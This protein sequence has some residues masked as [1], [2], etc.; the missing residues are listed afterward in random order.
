MPQ[1]QAQHI[2]DDCV[3]IISF[4]LR[5]CWIDDSRSLA[6]RDSMLLTVSTY[7]N[8]VSSHEGVV[9]A[10]IPQEFEI[11]AADQQQRRDCCWLQSCTRLPI[12]RD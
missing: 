11:H 4:A 5:V 8:H 2:K 6:S 12:A 7:L 10:S 3:V 1:P 9:C